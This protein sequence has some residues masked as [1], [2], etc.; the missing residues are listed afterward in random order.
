M[1]PNSRSDASLRWSD[2]EHC[3]TAFRTAFTDRERMHERRSFILLWTRTRTAFKNLMNDRKNGRS[4]NSY[5]HC[6]PRLNFATFFLITTASWHCCFK[7]CFWQIHKTKKF[8]ETLRV[9]T[10]AFCEK[11]RAVH[12]FVSMND[13][14]NGRSCLWTMP[15]TTVHY[16]SHER[17]LN[18]VHFFAH[19]REL[20]AVH[21]FRERAMLWFRWL[22]LSKA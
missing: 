20:N 21:F 13:S 3:R 7:K 19:E 1:S 2:A 6:L 10:Q 17:E 12:F 16:F 5:Q 4:Q 11:E 9:C 22:Q 18:A 15:W 8:L 14:V